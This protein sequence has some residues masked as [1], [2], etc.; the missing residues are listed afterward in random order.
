MR[1][2]GGGEQRAGSGDRENRADLRCIEKPELSGHAVSPTW[3]AD[4]E[5]VKESL[6]VHA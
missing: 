1:V 5:G 2:K 6:R 3:H 4:G